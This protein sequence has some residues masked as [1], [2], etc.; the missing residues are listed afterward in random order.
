MIL[1]QLGNEKTGPAQKRSEK[2]GTEAT[3]ED[4]IFNTHLSRAS[5][6]N[7]LEMTDDR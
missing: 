6:E 7:D 3:S 2:V 1:I 5:R 4:P